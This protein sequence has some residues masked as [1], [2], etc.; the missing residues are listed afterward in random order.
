MPIKHLVFS[1]GAYK[2]FYTLGA[3]KHLSETSFYKL[4]D[5]ENI[6]GASVGSIISLII[7]LYIVSKFGLK[8]CLGM[9]KMY[10]A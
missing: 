1:G 2:G 5:I 3:L 8:I 4:D 9:S 7:I 6:Y 10:P